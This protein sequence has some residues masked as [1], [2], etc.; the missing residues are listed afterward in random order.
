MLIQKNNIIN[1]I[2]YSQMNRQED[3]DSFSL[4]KDRNKKSLSPKKD[5]SREKRHKKN[6]YNYSPK[7]GRIS[8]KKLRIS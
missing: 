4:E 1:R 8:P 7:R 2:T 3:D 5:E 6:G